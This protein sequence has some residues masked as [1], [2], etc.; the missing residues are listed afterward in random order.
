MSVYSTEVFMLSIWNFILNDEAKLV[1]LYW[2][3]LYTT[4]SIKTFLQ[5][6][7]MIFT[8]ENNYMRLADQ[9]TAKLFEDLEVLLNSLVS[10]EVV[11]ML[12][13]LEGSKYKGAKANATGFKSSILIQ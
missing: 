9:S 13:K 3:Q 5:S 8:M 7:H 10:R 1:D 11:K 2:A 12:Q 4:T 6:Y